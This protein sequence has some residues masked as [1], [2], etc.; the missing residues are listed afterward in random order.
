MHIFIIKKSSAMIDILKKYWNFRVY[1]PFI[2]HFEAFFSLFW[3]SFILDLA[4]IGRA[5]ELVLDV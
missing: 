1:L 3:I 5:Q 2:I 4:Y